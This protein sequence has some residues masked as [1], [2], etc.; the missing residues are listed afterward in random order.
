MRK[1]IR[2]KIAAAAKNKFCAQVNF[3]GAKSVYMGVRGLQNKK[4]LP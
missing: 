2:Q 3:S 4:P 1:K